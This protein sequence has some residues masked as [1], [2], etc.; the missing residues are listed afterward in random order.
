MR[1]ELE[2]RGEGC[3]LRLT[4]FLEDREVAA[5]DAAGWHV[6]LDNLVR[7]LASGTGRAPST[8]PTEEWRGLYAQYTR[9]GFPAGAPVPD[10]H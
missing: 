8:R 7:Q 3:R 9:Q 5:R 2:A 4:N 10:D 1:F 6:C